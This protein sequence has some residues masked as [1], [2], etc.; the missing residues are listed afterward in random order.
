MGVISLTYLNIPPSLRN[1]TVYSLVFCIIPG[2]DSPNTTTIS[3]ILKP[4]VD[5]LLDLQHGIMIPTF[6]EKDGHL[7][8]VQILPLVGDF[9]AVHKT[10][11][12]L[13]H[14]AKQFCPW[15]NSQLQNLHNLQIG[16]TR[17]GIEIL[18]SSKKWKNAK[19]MTQQEEIHKAT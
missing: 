4:L 15:C 9:V 12:F 5:G 16:S 2:P 8:F 3:H 6:Q 10:A 18:E 11:G 1:K 17:S 19:T 13:S 7:I 14:S